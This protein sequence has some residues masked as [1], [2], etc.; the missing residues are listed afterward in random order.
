MASDFSPAWHQGYFDARS[1]LF[2]ASGPGITSV[3]LRSEAA[4]HRRAARNLGYLGTRREVLDYIDGAWH[5]L[6]IMGL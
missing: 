2:E 1:A 3:R 6:E 5:F 4:L